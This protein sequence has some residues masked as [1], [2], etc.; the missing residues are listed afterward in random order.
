MYTMELE[1][2]EKYLISAVYP[3]GKYMLTEKELVYVM[4][5]NGVYYFTDCN[6]GLEVR[7]NTRLTLEYTAIF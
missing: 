5:T 1:S 3:S 4:K 6:T 2:G 7:I